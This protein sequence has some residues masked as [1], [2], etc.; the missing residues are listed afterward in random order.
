MSSDVQSPINS[1]SVVVTAYNEEE[2]LE[3]F[4]SELLEFLNTQ[5]QQYE[6]IIVDDGSTDDTPSIIDK[7]QHQFKTI[8]A[9]RLEKNTGMG[10]ALKA[11]FKCSRLDWIT[12][13]P[14]DGQIKPTELMTM[15]QAV[16]NEDLDCV[17][18]MYFKRNYNLKRK[19]ISAV[20]HN[21]TKFILGRDPQTQG[22]YMLKK[23]V[24]DALNLY[25]NTFLFNLEL[26]VKVQNAGYK[27]RSVKIRLS[28]RIAGVSKAMQKPRIMSTLLEMLLVRLK[29]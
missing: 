17:T 2:C 4:I 14:A 9:L 5:S 11:G 3:I 25:S 15:A 21:L 20:I 6:I 28:P 12:F 23:S 7:L 10:A 13:F 26:P 19:I 18:S 27:F 24:Y 16:L 8:N 22:I 29:G 1:L